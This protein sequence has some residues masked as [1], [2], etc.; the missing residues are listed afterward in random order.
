MAK[1]G[2][3]MTN[4]RRKLETI[5]EHFDNA[6]LV[7]TGKDD[8]IRARPMRIVDRADDFELWFL[9][10][11]NTGTVEELE[12]DLRAAVLV[13]GND[14]Y[15]SLSGMAS[16]VDDRDTLHRLWTPLMKP[17]FPDGPDTPDLVAIRFVPTEGAYWDASGI[18]GVKYLLRAVKAVVKGERLDD[19]TDRHGSV[20]V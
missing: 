19:P 16:V 15:A 4:E 6:M 13:Q 2:V 3:T 1:P 10:S 17:W 11:R 5:I 18:E 9:T 12:G 7:T 8:M 20:T 14:E